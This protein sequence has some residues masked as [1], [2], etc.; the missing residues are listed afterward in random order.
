MLQI[1]VIAA[2]IVAMAMIVKRAARMLPPK[3]YRQLI[4]AMFAVY[5]CGNIYCTLCSR[6]P[7]SGT[8]L[9]LWPFM[10][11]YRLFT[12]PIEVG[13][14][15]TGLFAW[16]MNDA[17]PV[18]SMVLNVLLY[19]PMGYLLPVLQP[20]FS[21]KHVIAIGCLCSVATEIAQYILAMGWCETDDV[22]HN[23]LGAV[24]GVWMWHRS[25]T[26]I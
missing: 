6:V 12:T 7:G 21:R 20:K 19:V 17:S 14:E 5:L 24:V 22:I 25:N 23:T 8:T 10:S 3:R 16:F 1:I 4:W 9:Q 13:T 15:V 11:I 18:V 2:G 26:K